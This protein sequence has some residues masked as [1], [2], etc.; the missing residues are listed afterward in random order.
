MNIKFLILKTNWINLLGIFISVYVFSVSVALSNQEHGLFDSILE[1]LIGGFILVFGYGLTFWV[2]FIFL[3]T[4][5]DILLLGSNTQNISIKL[6]LEWFVIS[7]PFVYW[8]IVYSE[9]IFLVGIIAFLIT[10]Y[11]RKQQ[12]LNIISN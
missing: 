4:M 6:I 1:A 9:W 3:I 7:I 8:V 10:Q 12:I 5:L 11:I 2:G